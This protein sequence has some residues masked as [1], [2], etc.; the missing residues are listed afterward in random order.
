MCWGSGGAAAGWGGPAADAH[1]A[2]HKLRVVARLGALG[3]LQPEVGHEGPRGGVTHP[4]ATV[5]RAERGHLPK[6]V[7]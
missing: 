5:R 1:R 6:L 4:G 2:G 3:R 7:L